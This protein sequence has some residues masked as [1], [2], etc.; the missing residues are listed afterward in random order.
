M[1][2]SVN[3]WLTCRKICLNQIQ[4]QYRLWSDVPDGS[5]LFCLFLI[6]TAFIKLIENTCFCTNWFLNLNPWFLT[7]NMSRYT[8]QFTWLVFTLLILFW[9]KTELAAFI[10]S[11]YPCKPFCNCLVFVNLFMVISW[12]SPE[13]LKLYFLSHCVDTELHVHL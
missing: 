6:N 8:R 5:I 7:Q 13:T 12:R 9:R 11:C 3:Y 2:L 4:H 10:I 1:K